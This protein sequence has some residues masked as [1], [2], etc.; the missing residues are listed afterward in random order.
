MKTVWKIIRPK[1]AAF[2]LNTVNDIMRHSIYSGNP[3]GAYRF[4]AES[5]LESWE[6]TWENRDALLERKI[7]L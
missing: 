5:S 3:F 4:G 6:K 2:R 7:L 1:L